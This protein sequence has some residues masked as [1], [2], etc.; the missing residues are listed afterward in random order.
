[1]LP[2]S[3]LRLKPSRLTRLLSLRTTFT[4]TYNKSLRIV[5]KR[6]PNLVRKSLPKSTLFLRSLS[7]EMLLRMRAH[8]DKI[9]S[10]HHWAV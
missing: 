6:D 3:S 9:E 4:N 1:M 2:P 7:L 5:M 8:K 10:R